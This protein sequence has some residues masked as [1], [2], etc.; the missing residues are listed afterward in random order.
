MVWQGLFSKCL[1]KGLDEALG[2]DLISCD[3]DEIPN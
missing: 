3:L 1:L 2:E